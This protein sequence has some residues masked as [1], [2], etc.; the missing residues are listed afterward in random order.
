MA[1]K[2]GFKK[3]DPKIKIIAAVVV[4]VVVAITGY[5]NMEKIEIMV[6]KTT[7]SAPQD[8]LALAYEA[9]AAGDNDK[10]I[11]YYEGFISVQSKDNPKVAAAYT[12][13]GNIYLKEFKYHKAVLQFQKALDHTNEYG[14]KESQEAAAAWYS[15]GAV[16]DKQGEVKKALNHY[17]SSQTIQ[18]KLGVDTDEVDQVIDELEDYM[19]N[20]NLHTSS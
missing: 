16:Y 19:V 20:A 14:S 15:L 13:I 18:A 8:L 5:M 9:E 11:G 6:K 10:A 2:K 4:V 12:G 1:G 3:S 7:G 17:K